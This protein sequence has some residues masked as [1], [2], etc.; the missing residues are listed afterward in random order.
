MMLFSGNDFAS[1]QD[2]ESLP[3]FPEDA[4]SFSDLQDE[5][6]QDFDLRSAMQRDLVFLEVVMRGH[7]CCAL[8]LDAPPWYGGHLSSSCDLTSRIQPDCIGRFLGF[9][10]FPRDFNCVYHFSFVLSK[11]LQN[12][13]LS[14]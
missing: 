6:P 8:H 7:S 4:M 9:E 2:G 10:S 5:E 3:I 13:L 1:F 12:A 11:Q 14:L